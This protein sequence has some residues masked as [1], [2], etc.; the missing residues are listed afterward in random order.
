MSF[1]GGN[2]NEAGPVSNRAAALARRE[3]PPLLV[4]FFSLVRYRASAGC[5]V[6]QLVKRG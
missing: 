1:L 4:S 6:A 5:C 3:H 2:R